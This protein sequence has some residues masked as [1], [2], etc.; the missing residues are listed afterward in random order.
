MGII[1]KHT[2]S[3]N[4]QAYVGLTTRSMEE[5]WD[6]HISDS[7]HKDYHFYNAINKY[8]PD[9]WTHEV[10]AE[11]DNEIVGEAEEYWISYLDTF[12]N[13]YNSTTGGDHYIMSEEVKEK[14]AEA[15]RGLTL[16]DE[17]KLKMSLSALGKNKSKEHRENISLGKRGKSTSPASQFQKGH[18]GYQNK[19][20]LGRHHSEETKQKMRESH[21]RRLEGVVK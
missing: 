19:G 7:Q 1:Y 17:T 13:G 8:G 20:M 10:I 18:K 3:N 4:G 21:K 15:K 16:S 6:E 14:M 9:C 5:R 11:Y 2:N 12:R